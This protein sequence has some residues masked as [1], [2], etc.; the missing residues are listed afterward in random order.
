MELTV[1]IMQL[2]YNHSRIVSAITCNPQIPKKYILIRGWVSF[3]PN[4][5]H[6]R[7]CTVKKY[8]RLKAK[9]CKL[10]LIKRGL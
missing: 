9:Q 10:L 7:M 8:Y 5:W 2:T 4:V 3:V 1:S 6:G